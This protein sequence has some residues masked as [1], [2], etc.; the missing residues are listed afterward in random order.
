MPAMNSGNQLLAL[1]PINNHVLVRLGDK[2]DNFSTIDA[3]YETRTNGIVQ[4]IPENSGCEYLVNKRVFFEEYK[5]GARIKRGGE[6]YC[7]IK[8]DDITGYEDL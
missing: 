4:S 1:I 3:K 5:E 2:Y 7:F 8:I 6:Q